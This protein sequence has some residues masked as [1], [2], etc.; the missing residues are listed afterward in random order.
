[1]RTTRSRTDNLRSSRGRAALGDWKPVAGAIVMLLASASLPAA[2]AAGADPG[3]GIHFEI[4]PRL[5]T[6]AANERQ[7]TTVVH[8]SWSAPQEESL[9]LVLSGRP[10]IKRCWEHYAAGTYSLELVFAQDLTFELRDPGLRNILASA[11][12]R[13]IREALE[14]RHR[15]RQ[16][17]NIFD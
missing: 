10:E 8:A 2:A 6:L 1:V 7:C 5:C 12:L 3:V 11:V 4:A 9:C 17:W 16:P 13:V 15:R 14:Y